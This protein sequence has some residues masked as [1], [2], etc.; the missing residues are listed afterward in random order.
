MTCGF[1]EFGKGGCWIEFLDSVGMVSCFVNFLCCPRRILLTTLYVLKT[2]ICCL[3]VVLSIFLLGFCEL[4]FSAVV[5]VL[6][7]S[8]IPQR[9]GRSNVRET[10]FWKNYFYHCDQARQELQDLRRRQTNAVVQSQQSPT[11]GSYP[12]LANSNKQNSTSLASLASGGSM[13]GGWGCNSLIDSSIL[14]SVEGDLENNETSGNA[15][16]M[17]HNHYNNFASS[18]LTDDSSLV[19]ASLPDDDE[20]GGMLGETEADDSSYVMPS[21]PNSLNTFTTTRS[22]DDLVLVGKE[23]STGGSNQ[24]K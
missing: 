7:P 18:H 23:Y 3:C 1:G 20:V 6:N 22:V 19:P 11:S 16:M 24:Y 13:V 5:D 17:L 15:M 10:L 21:A 2:V 12:V 8:N 14:E 4:E 9:A